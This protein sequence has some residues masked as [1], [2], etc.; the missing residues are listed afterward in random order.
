MGTNV[1][2]TQNRRC[3]DGWWESVICHCRLERW[4]LFKNIPEQRD[5]LI[6]ASEMQLLSPTLTKTDTHGS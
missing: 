1:G 2:T 4:C 3:R 5:Q 6:M